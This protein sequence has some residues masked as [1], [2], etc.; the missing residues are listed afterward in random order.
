MQDPAP[1]GHLVL[2]G[3]LGVVVEIHRVNNSQVEDHLVQDLDQ[4][5]VPLDGDALVLLLGVVRFAQ[6]LL[7]LG[8]GL[9]YKIVGDVGQERVGG[10]QAQAD[11][12]LVVLRGPEVPL[13][14]QVGHDLGRQ[15]D[16]VP[17]HL[18][19]LREARHRPHPLGQVSVHYRPQL[20]VPQPAIMSVINLRE[21]EL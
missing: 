10:H 4:L 12:L 6:Q 20:A 8:V 19:V 3:V 2:I 21:T 14:V 5:L 11:I 16:V 18:L 9:L 15:L 7:L 17:H 1:V 13:G